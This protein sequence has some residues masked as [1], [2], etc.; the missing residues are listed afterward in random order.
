MVISLT[1]AKL[2]NFHHV[3][4]STNCVLKI[5]FLREKGSETKRGKSQKHLKPKSCCSPKRIKE[6]QNLDSLSI[7]PRY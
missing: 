4:F 3:Y 5:K 2:S 1:G 7:R 6:V